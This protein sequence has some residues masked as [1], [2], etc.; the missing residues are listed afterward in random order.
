MGWLVFLALLEDFCF[1]GLGLVGDPA[2][3]IDSEDEA[4]STLTASGVLVLGVASVVVVLV[5]VTWFP[6]LI[7]L[8][9]LMV[10]WPVG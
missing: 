1:V 7:L 2:R 8:L 5:L 9:I 10:G 4:M 6:I 3:T